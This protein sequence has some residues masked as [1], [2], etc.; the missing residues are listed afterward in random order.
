MK[1]F[2][3]GLG[4]GAS[5]WR[6][7]IEAMGCPDAVCPDLTRCPD[8]Q[9]MDYESLYREFCA[10]AER[11]DEPLELC[12]LSLGAMLALHFAIDHPQRVRRLA[13]VAPQVKPPRLLLALQNGMFRLMP[14]RAFA[15][16]GLGKQDCIRLCAS[17][18]RLDFSGRLDRVACK[19]LV[20]CGE[21]DRA[22]RGAARQ[23]AE[24]IAQA[25]LKFVGGAGHEVNLDAPKALAG[26][27][28][29]FFE[30]EKGEAY[31]NR[32]VENG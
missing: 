30:E 18:A 7:T 24:G 2:L 32:S 16:T 26:L 8:G 21:K 27:L 14:R 9:E 31:G 22:N 17:M 5:S 13:L 3:H 19:A 6:Q 23:A 20:I 12:G 25:E 4:Q 11:W 15:E 29:P 10:A 1:V 28:A